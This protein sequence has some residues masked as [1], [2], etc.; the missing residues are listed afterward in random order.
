VTVG[1]VNRFRRVT[2][3]KVLAVGVAIRMI[4]GASYNIEMT[5]LMDNRPGLR[6]GTCHRRVPESVTQVDLIGTRWI[7]IGI[8]I[9]SAAA[10]KFEILV[11]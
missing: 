7:N 2:R 5:H 3:S 8:V 4:V 1:I 11:C 10:V 6:I 9:P